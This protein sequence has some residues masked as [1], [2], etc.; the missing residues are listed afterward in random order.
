[1]TCRGIKDFLTALTADAA[2]IL[3]VIFG[4]G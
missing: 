2:F 3:F 4:T 1:M